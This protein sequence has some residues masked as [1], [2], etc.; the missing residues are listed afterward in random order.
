[1]NNVV[2][3]ANL[4]H[5][6]V[7]RVPDYQRGYSWEERQVREFLEDLDLLGLNRE[8]YTGT[9]VLCKSKPECRPR[10]G[11][12][13]R[14]VTVD[15]VDGQQR[16]TTIILLLDQIRTSL[17]GLSESADTLAMGIAKNYI[18]TRNRSGQRLHKL[19]LNQD[20]DEFFKDYILN[21]SGGAART[22][23]Q[24]RLKDAR[25]QIADYVAANTSAREDGGEKWLQDE[26]YFK[27]SEQVRFTL[28]EVE[29]EA[30]VGVIFELMNDRGK[31][32]TNLDK[33]KNHLLHTSK[34]LIVPDEHGLAKYVNDAWTTILRNMMEAGLSTSEDEDRLLRADWLTHYSYVARQWKG[35]R[36]AR[37]KFDLRKDLYRERHERLLSDLESYVRTLRESS[38][39]FCDAYSPWRTGAFGSFDMDT[40]TQKQVVQWSI[41][42]RRVGVLAPFLPL[43]IAMRERWPDEPQKYL[44]AVKICEKFAF[45]VYRL[46]GSRSNAGQSMLFHLGYDVAHE[47]VD[48]ERM[49]L[50]LKRELSYRCGDNAFKSLLSEGDQQIKEAYGWSGLR[51]FLYEYESALAEEQRASP[52][53]EWADLQGRDTIEHVLP[54]SIDRQPYWKDRFEEIHR[55]YLHDLGNLTLTK[56]NSVLLDKPFPNKRDSENA[57]VFCYAKSSLFVEKELCLWSDW[58]VDAV[59]ERRAKMLKWARGRVG[60]RPKRSRE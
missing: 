54:Q 13:T 59:E 50:R 6:R 40:N 49:I 28:Y 18:V 3:L 57:K 29:E 20:S 38:S 2:D 24:R 11:D 22:A 43:L 46:Q 7:F 52:R 51:Y 56:H 44:E 32:L 9:V 34:R 48:F 47:G 60:G 17:S 41:K 21:G 1:M 39:S 26:L 36:S 19:S 35:S 27:I 12:G 58:N 37:T 16:L 23:S 53:V 14:Y 5:G 45:R 8:H 4:F 33:V 10:D 31:P 25:A 42:L 55:R 15:V 30:D